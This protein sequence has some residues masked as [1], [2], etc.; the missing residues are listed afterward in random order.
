LSI[1]KDIVEAVIKAMG[2][3][4][5]EVINIGTGGKI[6]EENCVV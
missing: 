2:A 5:G 6:K 1:Y 4:K 3:R